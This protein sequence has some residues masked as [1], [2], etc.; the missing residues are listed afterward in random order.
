MGAF[1]SIYFFLK[2]NITC[3][4]VLSM[5][6]KIT[7]PMYKVMITR[8][9]SVDLDVL[10]PLN[11][12][13]HTLTLRVS[14]RIVANISESLSSSPNSSLGLAGKTLPENYNPYL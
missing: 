10:K 14:S 7:I 11:L 9:T 1:A 4:F 3:S 8:F 6:G 5:W 13:T 2:L 12:I